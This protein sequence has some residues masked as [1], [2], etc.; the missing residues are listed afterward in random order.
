MPRIRDTW[1]CTYD[2]D[3]NPTRIFISPSFESLLTW[4]PMELR[5]SKADY[6]WKQMD[7]ISYTHQ[8]LHN[9]WHTK[10][11]GSPFYKLSSIWE[12]DRKYPTSYTSISMQNTNTNKNIPNCPILQQ[13]CPHPSPRHT[14]PV[15]CPP[16]LTLLIPFT[17]RMRNRILPLKRLK[18]A[19]T[20]SLWRRRYIHSTLYPT[21]HALPPLQS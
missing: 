19:H 11:I 12:I 9:T 6:R 8:L 4:E 14:H 13:H 20:S 7:N 5:L 15:I 17:Y 16:Q 18:S 3:R 10:H 21:T 2:L 1:L